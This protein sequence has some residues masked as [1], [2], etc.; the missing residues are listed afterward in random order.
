VTAPIA[1]LPEAVALPALRGVQAGREFR[2]A[3]VKLAE[4]PH[5]LDAV[6]AAAPAEGRAQRLLSKARIPRLAGYLAANARDYILPP[7]A[8][9]IDGEARFEAGAAGAGVLHIPA[10]ARVSVIDGQHRRSAI[11]EAIRAM[12]ALRYEAVPVVFYLD[13]GLERC[14]QQF[15]D[16]NRHA[17]R[18]SGSIGILYDQRD[19]GA[20]LARLVVARVPVFTL[21]SERQRT[22]CSGASPMLFSLAGV[23]AATK[24]LLAGT[25][26]TRA[27]AEALAVAFWS[28]VADR[29]PGWETV[30]EGRLRAG[31]LRAR[32]VHGH[33]VALEALGRAG[34][35][36]VRAWPE[37]WPAALAGLA[38]LDWS[39]ANTALWDGRALHGGRVVKSGAAVVLTAS[40]IKLHLGLE[41]G[42]EEMH[43]EQ[44][45]RA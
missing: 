15:A 44:R 18:R 12:P 35:A 11:A 25:T 2:V 34:G 41:L 32:Y 45:R 27:E 1:G 20:R 14:Q 31:E 10:G 5:L 26:R 37:G 36:L 8:A 40:A 9:A 13:V 6:D 21:L 43:M 24:A 42:P 17:V 16:L 22:A 30:A 39:R 7:L 19:H 33:A 38:T 29:M 28:E 3:M 23:C 4:I